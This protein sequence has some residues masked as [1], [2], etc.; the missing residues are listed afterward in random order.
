MMLEPKMTAN[1]LIRRLEVRRQKVWQQAY[2]I[3]D[4]ACHPPRKNFTPAE[5]REYSALDAEFDRLD[6]QIHRL[7]HPPKP[8]KG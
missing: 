6:R 8:P 5:W 2:E 4:R 3:A 7:L 1:H